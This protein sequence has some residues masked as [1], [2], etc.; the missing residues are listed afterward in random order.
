[1]ADPNVKISQPAEDRGIPCGHSHENRQT[2]AGEYR[3][4]IPFLKRCRI[5][6]GRTTDVWQHIRKGW[7]ALWQVF[8]PGS[9]YPKIP[10]PKGSFVL[11]LLNLP[12]TH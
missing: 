8:H 5:A 3:R 9:H 7:P 1:M 2:C 12:A 10:Q 4:P 6:N 11:N